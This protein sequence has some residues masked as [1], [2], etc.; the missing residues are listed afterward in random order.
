MHA[1]LSEP[2][3]ARFAEVLV[4]TAAVVVDTPCSIET[5][6]PASTEVP[7][8]V[9]VATAVPPSLLSTAS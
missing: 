2:Q 1:G 9:V 8:T 7:G 4:V 6:R 5:R 3:G